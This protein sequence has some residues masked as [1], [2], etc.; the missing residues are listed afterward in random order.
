MARDSEWDYAAVTIPWLSQDPVNVV[1]T[2]GRGF[3]N[4]FDNE[5][6]VA[7]EARHTLNL[8]G[9]EFVA[10]WR[11]EFPGW[12]MIAWAVFRRPHR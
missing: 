4:V 1:F 3:G 8:C 6:V 9:W 10:L 5:R 12:N 7:T 11:H 2:S